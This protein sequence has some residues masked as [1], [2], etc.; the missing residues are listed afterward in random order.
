M[1]G[2][3][4]DG[5]DGVDGVAGTDGVVCVVTALYTYLVSIRFSRVD[6]SSYPA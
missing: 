1:A 5:V 4:T 2:V 6:A 3:A